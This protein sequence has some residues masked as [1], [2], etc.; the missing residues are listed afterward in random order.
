M[1][2]NDTE[3][4]PS[5]AGIR[6]RPCGMAVLAAALAVGPLSSACGDDSPGPAGGGDAEDVAPNDAADDGATPEEADADGDEDAGPERLELDPGQVVELQADGDGS[7]EGT[8][9]APAGSERFGVLLYSA[10]WATGQVGYDVAVT[11]AAAMVAGEGEAKAGGRPAWD[12]RHALVDVGRGRPPR[13]ATAP[14]AWSAGT[15]CRR[16]SSARGGRS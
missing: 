4:V 9:A 5:A 7:F 11:G 1:H 3:G 12:R 15:R 16:R 14:R 13:C 6:M 10:R 2:G 8:L